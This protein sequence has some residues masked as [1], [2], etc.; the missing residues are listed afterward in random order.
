M[1]AANQKQTKLTK[2]IEAYRIKRWD[3]LG[4]VLCQKV[5]IGSMGA[6]QGF[7]F[8]GEE[9]AKE[10]VYADEYNQ[11]IAVTDVAD[12]EAFA[13]EVAINHHAELTAE[14]EAYVERAIAKNE[15]AGYI[16][17]MKKDQAAIAANGPKVIAR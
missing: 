15:D 10:R 12:I 4:T 8:V 17:A 1:I 7:Y 9:T 6:K 11:F 2:G 3:G 13:M 14:A 16:T 5:T